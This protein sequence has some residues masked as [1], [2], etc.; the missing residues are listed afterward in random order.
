MTRSDEYAHGFSEGWRWAEADLRDH[1]GPN[2]EPVLREDAKTAFSDESRAFYLGALRG[3]RSAFAAFKRG[4][5]AR[6]MFEMTR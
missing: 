1:Q 4:R 5:L 3:Y 2:W 6:E